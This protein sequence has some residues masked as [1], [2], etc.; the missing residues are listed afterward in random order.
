MH[1]IGGIG[2]NPIILASSAISSKYAEL[3][4]APGAAVGDIERVVGGTAYVQHYNGSAI[5]WRR[6]QDA[7][8]VH[9]AI[10]QRWMEQGGEGSYLGL[11]RTDEQPWTDPDTNKAGVISH[12]DRG[13]IFFVNDSGET[14]EFPAR[15]VFHTSHIGVSSIGGWVQLVLTSAGSFHYRGHLHNSGFVGLYCTVATAVKIPGTDKAVAARYEANVGGTTSVDG[16]DEDWDESGFEQAIRD[17]WDALGTATQSSSTLE[18]ELG[19][20][21]VV[22]LVLLPIVGAVAFVALVSGGSPSNLDC[23][24]EGTHTV[25]DGNNHTETTHDGVRCHRR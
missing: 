13:A 4:G 2:L 11:P 22:T 6:S 8:W 20:W 1:E 21:E 12:F 24:F 7:F 16:R 14:L 23:S 3:H 5:Y 18:A 10:Y 25:L 19:G 9:G 15:K 17:N